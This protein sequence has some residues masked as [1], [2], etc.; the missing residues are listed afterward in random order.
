MLV[1]RFELS[2]LCLKG[3]CSNQLSY[4]GINTRDVVVMDSCLKPLGYM[5]QLKTFGFE[6]KN[7]S[8]AFNILSDLLLVSTLQHL[9]ERKL[10]I[11]DREKGEIIFR[12]IINS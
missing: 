9:I 7:G 10:F 4:T 1:E 3:K 11:S 12:Q 2:T 8:L 5:L 6:P